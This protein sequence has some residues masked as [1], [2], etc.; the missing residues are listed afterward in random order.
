MINHGLWRVR[1]FSDMVPEILNL[2]REVN[3]LFSDAGHKTPPQYP[4]VNIWEKDGAAVVSAELPGIDPEKLD[5]KVTGEN[6]TIAGSAP[7]ESL[8]EG[9]TYLRQERGAGSFQRTIVLPFQVDAQAVV[10]SYDK[11]I[12]FVTLPRA[13]DDL[14]KKIKIG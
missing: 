8:A 12:L 14:P 7:V 3:R 2:Q 10:A 1:R 13:T 4:A 5:I 6:L 9:E 11:G